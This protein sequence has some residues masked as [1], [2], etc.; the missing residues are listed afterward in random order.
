VL[1]DLRDLGGALAG[2]TDEKRPFNGLLDID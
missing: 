2:G 1:V